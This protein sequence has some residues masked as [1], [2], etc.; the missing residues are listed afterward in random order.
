[1]SNTDGK[2]EDALRLI[3]DGNV[4]EDSGR[5]DEALLQYEM[6]ISMAPRLARA[7]LNR[8]NVL[9]A[10]NDGEGAVAAYTTA[11]THNPGYAAAH[12]NLGNAYL[13]LNQ[14]QAALGSYDA[15]ILLKPDFVDAEVAR[16]IA[17]DD[18]GELDLAAASARR[19]LE[20]KP[21]Y[22]EA[23][24]NLLFSHNYRL[25][26]PA[27]VLLEDAK[28][29]GQ[30]AKT[31]AQPFKEWPNDLNP[32]RCLRVGFVSNDLRNHPVG[33][34]FEAVATALKRNFS[35]RLE[36]FAYAGR[37]NSDAATARIR[38]CCHSWHPTEGATDEQLARKIREDKIDILVDLSGHTAGNRLPMFAWKPAPVQVSWLGYFATTG[39]EAIDY[40]IA[41]HY[42]LPAIEEINFTEKIWHLPETRLCFTPPDEQVEVSPLPASVRGVFTFGCFNNLTK[43]NDDVVT[44]WSRVL[45][46]I[47]GS[48][49]YLKAKQLTEISV[50]EKVLTRF[51]VHGIEST[52]LT[53]QGQSSRAD[54]L[55]AYQNVDIALDP[56]PFPGGTTTV[57]SL[58]MGVPVLTLPGNSFLSRQGAGLLANAG[59]P[60]WIATGKDDYVART[61]AHAANLDGLALLRGRLRAQVLTS[62]IFD[63]ARF[64]GH[65]QNALRCMWKKWAGTAPIL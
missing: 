25:D 41:D 38:S 61:V 56:F 14:S 44:L 58:W 48:R 33:Y 20:L 65:L 28:N 31:L 43:M 63:A 2:Q 53:L 55:K 26:Q 18:I 7:H 19:V 37:S 64:A 5:L 9:L 6:A 45:S 11:L 16:G 32:E 23:Y 60:E 13:Q 51:A 12:F 3:E 4:L 34:F 62:P 57:E 15:A 24:S 35:G 17:L 50:R 29:Y 21:G 8:G 40:L 47:P 30:L 39:V 46:A 10:K 42:T 22:T 52:R 59:L 49:L 27:A 54:Y 1:M 36:L